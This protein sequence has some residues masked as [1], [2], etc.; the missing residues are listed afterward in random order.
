MFDVVEP[1]IKLL[2]LEVLLLRPLL[3]LLLL[4]G[5]SIDFVAIS[6]TDA[7]ADDINMTGC[8]IDGE[9]GIGEF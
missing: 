1:P 6:E 8:F 5:I 2:E 3:L 4:N 9:L 7:K